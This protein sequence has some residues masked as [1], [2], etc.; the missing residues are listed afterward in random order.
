MN[1]EVFYHKL[2]YQIRNYL[3][4]HLTKTLSR[5]AVARTPDLR[6]FSQIS[7]ST[8]NSERDILADQTDQSV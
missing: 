5:K 4:P 2:F 3:L 7:H 6:T 8:E 1:Q